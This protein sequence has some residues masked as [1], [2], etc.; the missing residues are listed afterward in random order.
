MKEIII[1]TLTHTGW[2]SKLEKNRGVILRNSQI[3]V[4]SEKRHSL[5]RSTQGLGN[6]SAL[7]GAI[8]CLS[9]ALCTSRSLNNGLYTASRMILKSTILSQVLSIFYLLKDLRKKIP[10]SLLNSTPSTQ[11]NSDCC[12][13]QE[14]S[15]FQSWNNFS[16]SHDCNSLVPG[17]IITII[18]EKQDNI[19]KTWIK[20]HFSYSVTTRNDSLHGSLS[21]VFP[22]QYCSLQKTASCLSKTS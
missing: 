9:W 8:F 17:C 14:S 6:P 18:K 7:S 3:L 2:G 1:Q 16:E 5:L 22:F 10:L 11:Y 4:K 19:N 21:S 12:S 20:N 13:L 15:F